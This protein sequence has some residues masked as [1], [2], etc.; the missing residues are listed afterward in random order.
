MTETLTNKSR[1]MIFAAM[2]I[3][4]IIGSLLQTS[5][6]TA[7]PAIINSFGITAST[8][9]WLTSA[10]ALAMGVMV[11]ATPFL[12]KRFRTKRL[13][14]SGM[15][16]YFIGLLLASLSGNFLMLLLGRI[17]QALGNGILLSM[18]Q[19]VILTIFPPEKR[20]TAMGIYGLAVGA[21]PVLAPTITGIVIDVFDWHAIFWFALAIVALNII[22]SSIYMK[23][24]LENEKQHLDVISL[25]LST[26][27][28][29]GLLIGLGNL[30]T[31]PLVS[32]IVMLPIIIG[33]VTLILFIVRQLHSSNPFLELRTFKNRE[34]KLSVIMS[35][36]L[37]IVMIAGS[38]LI[39][40]YI[41]MV[42]GLSA[43]IS[44]LIMM[45]GSL[46][47]AILSPFAGRIYDRFGIKIL[48]VV[49]SILMTIS[50]FGISFVSESTSIPYL[51]VAYMLRLIAIS[52]MMMPIV[53]WGMSTMDTD[54]TSHG[55][56]ILTSLRTI[57][58]AISSAVFVAI[59]TY[60]TRVTSSSQ[61]VIINVSGVNASFISI[62]VVSVI[63]LIVSVFFVKKV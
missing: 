34:F 23:D 52:L 1:N 33:V 43:T 37:Y 40:M 3:S 4:S 47:M 57:A 32:A 49:G 45:P 15:G 21:A 58:G 9:Q 42:R 28:F 19:V 63:L 48:A 6:T 12:L 38:T 7:I 36:L 61:S 44:G 41:Q 53:T 10:Y 55:S 16:M 2:M 11:P 29:S 20:G 62:S 51:I 18:T 54:L 27:G 24:I 56:A 22:F 13:F 35:L 26:V 8:A 30:G 14:L 59:M 17:V 60:V 50:C 46:A 5:L 25:T 31:E 39:P